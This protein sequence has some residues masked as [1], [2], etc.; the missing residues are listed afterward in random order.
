MATAIAGVQ[1]KNSEIKNVG[2]K[3]VAAF[4][5]AKLTAHVIWGGILGSLGSVF[6][7]SLVFRGSLVMVLSV[8]M[9]GVGLAM[10]EVHPFFRR[11]LIQT[12]RFLGKYI[13]ATAKNGEMVAP[14]ILGFL[15]VF[16]PCGITQAM[17]TQSLTSG[18]FIN[19]ATILGVFV[20]GTTPTFALIGLALT[21]IGEA[22]QK[23]LQKA[24][25]IIV[26]GMAVWTFNTGLVMVGSPV[27]GQVIAREV[28]C[29]LAYCEEIS[30]LTIASEVKIEINQD[31]YRTN[32]AV[33][34]SG[35]TIKVKLV[36]NGGAGCQ[37]D[38]TIPSLNISKL[39]PPGSSA[40]LE[41]VAPGPGVLAYSC[42]MGMYGG[43]FR[44]VE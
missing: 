22:V 18:S 37:Q 10:W 31:G 44:V 5:V 28:Y 34:K 32:H 11:F 39:V 2:I 8:Y 42:G 24:A 35:E 3:A 9:V 20:L 7:P 26:V 27:N 15:T 29:G 1:A 14:A 36:N 16:I 25:A 40:E 43:Q 12:P 6:A 21:K 13:R 19:G 41:F 38:F 4:L 30:D 33:I 17:M 23:Y